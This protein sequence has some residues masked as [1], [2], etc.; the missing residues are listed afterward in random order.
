MTIFTPHSTRS[1]STCK[2]ATKAPI[3]TVL[4]TEGWRSIRTFANYYNKQIDDSEMFATSQ[5]A[6]TCSTLTI[7]TLEQGVKYVQS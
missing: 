1:A 4:R 5:S 6:F 7:K 2:A 3:E